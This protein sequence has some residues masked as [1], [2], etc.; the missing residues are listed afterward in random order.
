MAGYQG[1]SAIFIG[2]IPTAI[3]SGKRA[4]EAVL[5]NADPAEEILIPYSDC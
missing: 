3:E 1:F 5:Q 4:A 2:G